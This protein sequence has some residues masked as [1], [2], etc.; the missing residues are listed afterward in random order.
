MTRGEAWTTHLG[1]ALVGISG[2]VYA[3][4]LYVA[5]PTDEFAIVN[6][7]WQPQLLS[8]HI[9]TA[10]LLVLAVGFLWVNH[11]WGRI[12]SGYP[13]RR[14]TGLILAVAVFPMI[15]SGYAI[16]VSVDETWRAI[17]IGVHL[18]SSAL[19]L[20]GYLIHQFAPRGRQ[21]VAD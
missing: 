8:L 4:M 10:P 17:W 15:V 18:V 20:P 13:H 5:E 21:P 7:P 9:L 3:W 14:A 16:Q 19:W 11:I 6:H 12:R 2:L 1:S